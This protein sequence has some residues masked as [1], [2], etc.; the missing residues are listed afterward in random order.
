MSK[1]KETH[2]PE[3]ITAHAGFAAAGGPED[4]SED[5]TLDNLIK[6]I[7][8]G[9]DVVEVDARL[10]TRADGSS[11]LVIDHDGNK[12]DEDALPLQEV[13]SLLVGTHPRSKDLGDHG[14]RVKI[15]VDE[16]SDGILSDVLDLAENMAFPWERLICAGDSTYAYVQTQLPRLKAA[17]ER[18][19][20]F[21]MNPNEISSY[22]EMISDTDRFIQRVEALNLPVFTVNSYYLPFE[23]G[24]LLQRFTQAGIRVSVWTLNTSEI[25]EQYLPMGFYNVT[26]RLPD[27][28]AMRKAMLIQ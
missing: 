22:E 28:L 15:Q 16:K 12:S 25:L 24:H 7:S 13:F 5:N 19:M 8:Y 17:M 14:S 23:D 11:R 18:G 10:V 3:L 20:E 27:A 26:S 1:N 21:W 6:A 9:P 2:L 4:K